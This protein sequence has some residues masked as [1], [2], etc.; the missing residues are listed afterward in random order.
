[1]MRFLVVA[2]LAMA[3]L[4]FVALA[5][6]AV[7]KVARKVGRQPRLVRVLAIELRP[8]FI[9][10]MLT[11]IVVVV[12]ESRVP[13]EYRVISGAA[14]VIALYS[15]DYESDGRWQRRWDRHLESVRNW[16]RGKQP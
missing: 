1:M 13:W 6:D 9:V 8:A 11:M 10:G 4:V 14:L 2:S 3:G 7:C 16:P 15:Y 5:A 12:L